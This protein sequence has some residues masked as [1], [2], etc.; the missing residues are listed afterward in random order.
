MKSVET[1]Y[2]YSSRKEVPLSKFKR[3]LNYLK[4]WTQYF[5]TELQNETNKELD[6]LCKKFDINEVEKLRKKLMEELNKETLKIISK[7]EIIK[8]IKMIHQ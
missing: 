3:G 4:W 2:A 7:K 8:L 1:A 6:K 5:P